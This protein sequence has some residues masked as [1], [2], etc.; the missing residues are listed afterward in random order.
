MSASR[1]RPRHRALVRALALALAA[2]AMASTPVLAQTVTGRVVD[3]SGRQG[4]GGASVR[5]VELGRSLAT[6]RDGR[7]RANGVPP[8]D[9]TLEVRFVGAPTRTQAI[10]VPAEGVDVGQIVI[11]EDAAQVLDNVLVVGQLAGQAAAINQQRSAD[12]LTAGVAADA[13]GPFPDQNVAEA[14]QRLPGGAIARDPGEGRFVVIRGLDPSLNTTTI[15]GVRIPGPEDDS[16]QVNL[17]VIS[18][19][20]LETLEVTKT[21]TPDMD[22]DSI[23]GNVEIKGLSAFDR[24]GRSASAR[25]EG[26]WNEQR[27]AFSPKLS[28]SFADLVGPDERLGVAAS[29]SWFERKFGSSGVETATFDRLETPAGEE[30]PGIAEGEQR[31]YRITRERTSANL[32]FDWRPD[33]DSEYFWRTLFS[34]FSDDE[35]QLTNVFVFDDGDVEALDAGAGLFSDATLEKLT[36]ARVQTQDIFSTSIGGLNH[37]ERWSVDYSAAWSYADTEESDSFGAAWIQEGLDLGYDLGDPRRPRLFA[38]DAAAFADAGAYALDEIALEPYTTEEDETALTLNLQRDFDLG[39][40]FAFVKFGGKAR[41]R[42]KEADFD[43]TIFDGFGADYSLADFDLTGVDYPFGP[44]VPIAD[45]RGLSDFIRNNRG[46]FEIDQ[47]DTDI[48]RQGGDYVIDEDILAA[49][50]MVN[51]DFGQVRLTGGVRVEQTDFDAAG[52]RVLIDEEGGDGDPVF[53]PVRESKSYTDWLPGLHLRWEPYDALVVRASANR[54]IARPNFAYSAPFQVIEIEEDDGE[55]ER[56]AELGN[57]DLDPL[58]STNLDVSVEYYPGGVSVLSAALFYKRIKDFIVIADVAGEPGPFVDFDEAIQPLNGDRATVQGLELGY[59][60]QLDFLP[61]AL[62]GFLVSANFTFIDSESTLPFR[63]GEVPLPL[64]SDQIGNLTL[65][66]EN[67]GISV[68]LA[69]TWRGSYLDEIGELD[70][71]A[72][73]RYVD[74]HFQLDLTAKYRISDN[75]QAYGN[76]INLTD[77]PFYAYFGQR[78]FNSQYETYGRTYELGLRYNY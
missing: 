61:E 59:T 14:L 69:G 36:E 74:D 67:H 8:G 11:G 71:P 6:G 43:S 39:D 57:P 58:R 73:D 4:F 62:A 63:D 66:Y 50:A 76:A 30:L 16:R 60:R 25:V 15:N 49:Y 47:E 19:D 40:N 21:A 38:P 32:N 26:S 56:N 78:R 12:N 68:R 75:L 70:D 33:D 5:I 34:R 29:V 7:F 22:G 54:T 23:G 65:G 48:E 27:D 13:I 51:V 77:R 72:F 20:L 35:T 18:S 3:A 1:P 2:T 10:T 42:G 64:Q 41:L 46:A 52:T 55:F 31:D 17:D 9:Y 28:A 24:G 37:L 44:F 53:E 45:P